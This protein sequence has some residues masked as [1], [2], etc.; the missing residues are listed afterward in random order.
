M[1]TLNGALTDSEQTQAPINASNKVEK[2]QLFLDEPSDRRK[3]I[4]KLIVARKMSREDAEPRQSILPMHRKLTV[5]Q[6]FDN[7]LWINSQNEF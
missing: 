7:W 3:E 2:S 1:D 6:R 4:E 5:W